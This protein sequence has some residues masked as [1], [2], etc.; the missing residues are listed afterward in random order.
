[1]KSFI[2]KSCVLIVALMTLLSSCK[3][4]IDTSSR[5][6]F[7]ER[8]IASYLTDHSQ[9]TEFVR[10]LKE[11]KVSEMSNTSVYQLMT[12]YGNYTVFAP[13]NEAI[14]L[15]LDSLAL[16]G[17]IESPSWDGF[18]SN[19]VK[20]SIRS[21]IVMNSIIDGVK[22]QKTYYISNFPTK[23]N[24]EFD[25]STMADCKITV[26][27]DNKDKDA[28][29]LDGKSPIHKLNRDITCLNGII[30]ELT[31]PISPTNETLGNTL[32]LYA[33]QPDCGY[34]VMGKLIEAC[35]LIDTLS[36][37]KDYE[38]ERL[39]KNGI[40]TAS[41]WNNLN[42]D[43]EPT[44]HRRIGF[45]LF[46][47]TDDFW[48]AT[49]QKDVKDITVNDVRRWVREQN[50]YPEAI[51]NENFADENN[52]LNQFVTYHLLPMRIPVDKLTLHYN[53]KGFTKNGTQMR[54]S[55]PVWSHYVT[56]GKRRLIR[57]WESKESNGV[58]VNRFP[59]LNNERDGDYHE[60]YCEEENEGIYLNTSTESLTRKL[61]NAYIYPLDKVLV[62]DDHTRTNLQKCRLRYDVYEMMPEA[63]TNDM[64]VMSYFTRYY[65]PSNEEYQYFKDFDVNTKE[66][67]F[68]LLNGINQ[69][70]PNY[71]ADEVLCE[72]MY[73]VTLRLPP[74]PKSGVYEIRMGVSTESPWRG[75]CQVYFG[76]KKDALVPAGIPVNMALGGNS[77][78]N[79]IGWE[80]DNAND[81]DYNAE[82][83]KRI[84]NNG[85][86][87]GPE[88]LSETIGGKDVLRTLQKTTR[89]ILVRQSM[90]ADKVYYMRF[91]TVQDNPNKQLFLDYLEW[92]P[93]EIFDNP[94]T[95]E[96][97]W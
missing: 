74:V 82:I 71:Q 76:D 80:V 33:T 90:D 32:H 28:V 52:L 21:V 48:A 11:Q 24:E 77:V 63:M 70:W 57:L 5:Y 91:K 29:V 55:I 6:V 50:F 14:Q 41:H 47:E 87:K 72:G 37:F 10:L 7:K 45:T 78:P 8:T 64:R 96:D 44:E 81:L 18:P 30:H 69:G 22:A 31:Y 43:V 97:I 67:T 83:D 66:M 86:M 61:F 88:Y 4:E 9:F 35:N 92:C 93:K 49:L 79:I 46:A 62:Y 15:Y 56:M 58:Y 54:I 40:I 17:I 36:V 60:K 39:V 75:I 89:R 51:D 73:D 27:F 23:A 38:W 34:M 94:E 42:T 59:V 68:Y 19:K 65:F 26:A 25:L 84:R 1:M 12:A 53:E 85:F 20:D 95:P 13:S 3:E 16:R 2:S